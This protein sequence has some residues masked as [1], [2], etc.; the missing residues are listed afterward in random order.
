MDYDKCTNCG[1]CSA[2]CPSSAMEGIFEQKSYAADCFSCGTCVEVC[3]VKAISFGAGK[4]DKRSA[5][6]FEEKKNEH[7]ER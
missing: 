1:A 4:R 3:P 2:A 7:I 5:E 6:M